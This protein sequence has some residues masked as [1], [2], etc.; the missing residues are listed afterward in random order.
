LFVALYFTLNGRFQDYFYANF[1]ANAL[2]SSAADLSASDLLPVF[3]QQVTGN[4]LLWVCIILT[5]LYLIMV[6]ESKR[7]EKTSILALLIWSSM[8]LLGASATGRFYPH[9]FLHLLP[10]ACLLSAYL[11][12]KIVYP[13]RELLA[14]KRQALTLGLVLLVPL[15]QNIYPVLEMGA[16]LVYFRYGQEETYWGNEPLALAAYLRERV[17]PDDY[18]YVVDY[19]PTLYYL[20]PAKM[21][22]R[23]VFP[24]HLIDEQHAKLRGIDPI[25]ELAFII[26]KRP[27][28]IIK[29]YQN[30]NLFYAELA[31]Y[32][33]EYYTLENSVND[34]K[35]YRY[36]QEN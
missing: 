26:N 12:V 28:Y 2:Y 33:E 35:L 17:G 27:V 7:Q 9:Y 11:I 19:A 15:L 30:N 14:P 24:L 23:Y 3:R 25:R 22:T 6:K 16:A 29:Q 21:P 4:A 18:I 34:V 31:R 20:V 10:P 8:A 36:N 5:P 13:T 1:V 32:L